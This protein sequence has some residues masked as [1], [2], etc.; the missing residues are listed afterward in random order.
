MWSMSGQISTTAPLSQNVSSREAPPC[1]SLG[2]TL[3]WRVQQSRM[4]SSLRLWKLVQ[5]PVT[6]VLKTLFLHLNPTDEEPQNSGTETGTYSSVSGSD[7]GV[8]GQPAALKAKKRQMQ[9][10]VPTKQETN[11][12]DWL[13]EAEA[14]SGQCPA[15]SEG[16]SAPLCK[17][18]FSED[19][20]W[21]VG[22]EGRLR[23]EPALMP[24][25][26]IPGMARRD[27]RSVP[28][29]V[30]VTLPLPTFAH[31]VEW[32]TEE[33]MPLPPQ[34]DTSPQ[35]IS[36]TPHFQRPLVDTP[37]HSSSWIPPRNLPQ[38]VSSAVHKLPVPAL[39][40]LIH[41]TYTKGRGVNPEGGDHAARET[42]TKGNVLE[43][44]FKTL[45]PVSDL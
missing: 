2:H 9:G 6:S 25:E 33:P 26:A 22:Q 27:P 24:L 39:G 37:E 31:T 15:R 16:E 30:S 45:L 14:R 40:G 43:G 18:L 1:L 7:E 34:V 36:P 29:A 44:L 5:E 10:T 4:T 8:Y 35:S 23:D 17:P 21:E 41:P 38:V 13:V 12:C 3:R 19:R 11:V 32:S 42:Q 28:C 20:E